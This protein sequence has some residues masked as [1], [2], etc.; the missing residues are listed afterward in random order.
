MYVLYRS[1]GMVVGEA[2]IF[3]NKTTTQKKF[4]GDLSFMYQVVK[5]I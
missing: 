4:K 2:T 1:S 5:F 3:I